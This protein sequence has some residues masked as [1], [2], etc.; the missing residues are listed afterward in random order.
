MSKR[1]AALVSGVL[2][3]LLVLGGASRATAQVTRSDYPARPINMIVPF[4]PAGP[5]DAV[6]RIVAQKLSEQWS[7]SVVVENRSGAGG[8][9]GVAA[10][11]K[12]APDG[13]TIVMGGS[14]NLAVAPSLYAKLPYDPLR[15][16]TP[17]ANVASGPYVLAVHA[18][19]PAGSV[20]ELIKLASSK[21]G[22][23]SYG[24]AG[25]G[26][27]SHL[28]GELLR[29][30]AGIDILQVPYKGAGP[31]VTAVLV[32][33]IDIIFADFSALAPSAKAGKIRLLAAIGSKRLAAAPQLPTMAEAGI[34]DYAVDVWFGIMAPAGTPKDNV[35]KLNS[36]IVRALNAPDVRERFLRLGYEAIG[37]TPEQF[38]ATIRADIEKFRRIVRSANITVE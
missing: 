5:T 25:Q 33:E 30:T 3:S 18:N 10:A 20:Q 31:L 4:P 23:L 6:A 16:L 13:Y 14:S 34:R 7:Q 19:V 11:T 21:K 8:T 22:L 35:A 32:G 9:I 15:D 36:A 12:A 38:G 37:G 24:S 2:V 17:V 27:S 29:S 28:A 26:S 1:H